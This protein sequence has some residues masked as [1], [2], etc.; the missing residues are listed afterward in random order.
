LTRE[1]ELGFIRSRAR[2]GDL[3]TGVSWMANKHQEITRL[4]VAVLA[5]VIA[6]CGPKKPPEEPGKE[7]GSETGHEGGASTSTLEKLVDRLNSVIV[8][9]D[10]AEAEKLLE[11]QTADMLVEIISV[12]PECQPEGE[13]PALVD[14][15]NWEKENGIRYIV[16]ELDDDGMSGTVTAKIEDLDEFSGKMNVVGEGENA[17]LEFLDLAAERRDEILSQNIQREKLVEIVEKANKAISTQDGKLF[18]ECLTND[19]INAEVKLLS[20]FAK[21]KKDGYGFKATKIKANTGDAL[22]EVTDGDGN[23]VLKGKMKFVSEI[24]KMRMEYTDL[25]EARIDEE[26]A[27]LD[28]KK[29]K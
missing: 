18:Q 26:Q 17:R 15:L 14:Y 2:N 25:L 9:G 16:E 3:A 22:L 13:E 29:G 1:A 6:A 5:V 10:D 27:K 20:Y 8:Q 7:V 24:G 4:A 19:T 11:S 21:K 23:V 28:A 12:N